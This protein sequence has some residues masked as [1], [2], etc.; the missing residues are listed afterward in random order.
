MYTLSE[1]LVT[2]DSDRSIIRSTSLT[3]DSL[4]LMYRCNQ[5]HEEEFKRKKYSHTH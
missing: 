4:L 5:G 2:D 1:S 3:F